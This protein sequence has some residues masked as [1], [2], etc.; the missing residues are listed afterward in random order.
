VNVRRRALGW[1][2]IILALYVIGALVSGHMSPLARRPLLDGFIPPAPYRWVRPPP[3]L[4]NSNLPPVSGKTRVLFGAKG[5]EAA[6]FATDDAQVTSTVPE[7][8]FAARPGTEAVEIT[9][10]PVD[11]ASVEPLPG[12]LSVA[13]NVYLVRATYEPTGDP[14]KRLATS[15]G[16]IMT[17]PSLSNDLGNHTLVVSSNGRRWKPVK[18]FDQHATRQVNGRLRSLGYVAVA[19][20]PL[21]SP[22]GPGA[23]SPGEGSILPI[24]A[25]LIG[26]ALLIAGVF[27]IGRRP[28]RRDGRSVRGKP[29]R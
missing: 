18:T 2:L 28:D 7:D 6:F 10:E 19:S 12:R 22:A 5:S 1:G 24:L 3:E 14:V 16:V 29:R 13:G 27:L 17:Y 11:P 4:A 21:P 26:G 20:T 8:A 15:L 25:V 9:I 23:G